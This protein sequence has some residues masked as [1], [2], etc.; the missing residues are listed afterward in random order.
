MSPQPSPAESRP[1][2]ANHATLNIESLIHD[3]SEMLYDGQRRVNAILETAVDAIIMI[4]Q[5]GHIAEFNPAAERMFGYKIEE[6]LG[7]NINMLMPSPHQEKH[8]GYLQN[9]LQTGLRKIIGIGREVQ[10]LRKDGTLFDIDLSVA[11]LTLNGQTY[12]T[13]I[14]KDITERKANEKRLNWL[15]TIVESSNQAIIGIDQ[16][17]KI[18]SWNKTAE[19]IF[20]YQSE[21]TLNE[22][23]S[24]L[25]AENDLIELLTILQ[26]I[27]TGEASQ[28][29]LGIQAISKSGAAIDLNLSIS[30]ILE[31][32]HQISGASL[33]ATDMTQSRE[34]GRQVQQTRALAHH[35][36]NSLNECIAILDEE[37]MILSVNSAWKQFVEE[38]QVTESN[39]TE[40]SCFYPDDQPQWLAQQQIAKQIQKLFDSEDNFEVAPFIVEDNSGEMFFCIKLKRFLEEHESRVVVAID[41]ISTEK[42][43]QREMEKA[44]KAAE[45]ANLAKTDFLTNMSHEIRT[46]LTAILG[47]TELLVEEKMDAE[48]QT[49]SLK[50]I[51]RNGEHLLELINEILDLSKIESGKLEIK[52]TDCAIIELLDEL[53]EIMNMRAQKLNL[54]FHT[55]FRNALPATI[56]TDPV[57]LKQILFNLFGNATKFT[58]EGEICLTISTESN[59]LGIPQMKFEVKDSGIGIDP[60]SVSNL[61]EP[62]TQADSSVSRKYGGTGLGLSISKRLANLLGGDIGV[63]STPGVGSTFWFTIQTDHAHNETMYPSLETFREKSALD[64]VETSGGKALNFNILLAEDGLDNQRLFEFILTQAGARLTIV[65][66][67]EDAVKE[68]S[69]PGKEYDFILMDMQMP[70]MDGYKATKALRESGYEKPILALTAHAIESMQQRCRD[71]G[72][73]DV[74]T[75][76]VQRKNLLATLQKWHQRAH[77]LSEL[78]QA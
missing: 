65:N 2:T 24:L 5:F 42:L 9:Y 48:E 74:V 45:S 58:S 41:D 23:V 78:S 27:G 29:H 43:A 21:E 32:N 57:R 11:E 35:T 31:N 40:G 15:A 22:C 34:M 30:P 77:E 4:D 73:D 17:L 54:K 63:D 46:P 18:H 59:A 60:R 8:D 62:F 3:V 66:N 64:T 75:K 14:I 1:L 12:F 44:A 25:F 13:G 10:A 56:K 36:L 61:F 39:L 52:R 55:R 7:K 50:T 26:K 16:N 53:D 70:I 28:T 38:L 69:N 51:R 72:C 67:G 47:F 19:S 71:A 20:G 76:P 68:A 6:V 37:G 33:I 49:R